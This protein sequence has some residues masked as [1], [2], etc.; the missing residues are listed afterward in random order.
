MQRS[1]EGVG[2][3][4]R[5]VR[6]HLAAVE[7]QSVAPHL[8]DTHLAGTRRQQS[9]HEPQMCP[10]KHGWLTFARFEQ[11]LCR[12]RLQICSLPRFESS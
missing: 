7:A 9:F 12:G 8:A 10:T 4:H 5:A 2:Y 11:K 1:V 6:A 3:D